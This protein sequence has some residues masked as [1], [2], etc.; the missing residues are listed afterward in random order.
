MKSNNLKK[1]IYWTSVNWISNSILNPKVSCCYWL[2]SLWVHTRTSDFTPLPSSWMSQGLRIHH[3]ALSNSIAV[4]AYPP[5]S[6]SPIR[7]HPYPFSITIFDPSPGRS[8]WMAPYLLLKIVSLIFSQTCTDLFDLLNLKNVSRNKFD[9]LEN[10]CLNKILKKKSPQGL[11][12]SEPDYKYD[13]F[14]YILPC[15][16]RLFLP[17][18][19]ASQFVLLAVC[20]THW[21]FA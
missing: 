18:Q 2:I 1:S 9:I 6:S 3:F 10:F 15:I 11:I 21:I 8:L 13:Y 17:A 12:K 16:E 14:K 5:P 4:R 20:T 7:T 19:T